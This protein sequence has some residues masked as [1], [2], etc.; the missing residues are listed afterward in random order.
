M[1]IGRALAARPSIIL[2]DEPT[3]NLD[4]RNSKDVVDLLRLSVERYKQT[5]IMITHNDNYA[6]IA[7]RV[8][9]VEDGIVTEL[10]GAA[11]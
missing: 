5:V 10:G 3:W 1:A 11:I 8:L 4:S 6:S 2:A 7:G 9:K